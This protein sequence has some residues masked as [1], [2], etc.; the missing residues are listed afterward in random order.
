MTFQQLAQGARFTFASET[1]PK[2]RGLRLIV[3]ECVKVSNRQYRVVQTGETYT[4]G[5]VEVRVV[6]VT[7]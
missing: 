2:M 5:S 6:K 7:V 1:Q 4:V 3:G